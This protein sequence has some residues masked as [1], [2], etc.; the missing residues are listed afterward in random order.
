M[1]FY[2]NLDDETQ[3]ICE[4]CN[5]V[6]TNPLC[7]FCLAQEIE[8]WL[9]LY[10]T[11]KKELTP[12]I[13]RYLHN[14]ANHLNN[15]GTICIKCGQKQTH[16]CPYC[17]TSFIFSELQKINAAHVVRKEFFKFFNYRKEPT[18]YSTQH[19]EKYP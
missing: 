7:P 4:T 11:L 14:I 10:P 19:K 16:V 3:Y 5:G 6:I 17:F 12:H 15:Y 8:A 9:T 2:E 1:T 13:N 18:T